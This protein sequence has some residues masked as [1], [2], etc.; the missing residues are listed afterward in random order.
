MNSHELLIQ[1]RKVI[2]KLARSEI[3]TYT[4]A[5]P[6]PPPPFLGQG[7]IRLIVLGQRR[8][9]L[10]NSCIGRK[11][12]TW[13]KTDCPRGE[14]VPGGAPGRDEKTWICS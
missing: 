6:I 3:S 7:K 12:M 1:T 11:A 9:H 13:A 4:V 8:T 2:D 5:L 10:R 14:G